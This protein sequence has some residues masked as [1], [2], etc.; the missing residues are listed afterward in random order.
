[1]VAKSIDQNKYKN[2]GAK[3][4]QHVANNASEET[5]KDTTSAT[6]LVCS[7]AKEIFKISKGAMPG[8]IRLALD[9]VMTELKKHLN[10]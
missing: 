5:V 7:I 4:V 1:M 10:L 6:V 2:I 9:A 8:E 3:L